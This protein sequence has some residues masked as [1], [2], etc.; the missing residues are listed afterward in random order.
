MAP[1]MAVKVT[2]PVESIF[3][4]D[5]ETLLLTEIKD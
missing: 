5:M 4:V 2:Y 1:M 3:F